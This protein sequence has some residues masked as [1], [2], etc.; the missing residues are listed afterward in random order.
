MPQLDALKAKFPGLSN[1]LTYKKG[2]TIEKEY[3]HYKKAQGV[4]EAAIEAYIYPYEFLDNE[5]FRGAT[6]TDHIATEVPRAFLY[7][8]YCDYQGQDLLAY[9]IDDDK[10]FDWMFAGRRDQG[11]DLNGWTNGLIDIEDGPDDVNGS[12]LP[13]PQ[14]SP[15]G[16]K[17]M[18]NGGTITPPTTASRQTTPLSPRNEN[19]I[20]PAPV[21]PPTTLMDSDTRNM[22]V[23]TFSGRSNAYLVND[24]GGLRAFMQ[25][26][27]FYCRH[28]PAC[29]IWITRRSITTR[30]EEA[31]LEIIDLFNVSWDD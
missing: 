4:S 24:K 19:S 20:L 26:A 15:V 21:R 5:F 16:L 13:R 28:H 1:G 3:T 2:S 25:S 11:W 30:P 18:T 7:E 12:P 27:I 23:E 8:C 22:F 31:G 17:T 14:E 6:G 29:K 9:H 10:L